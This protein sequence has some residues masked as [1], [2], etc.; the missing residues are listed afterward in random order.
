[1]IGKRFTT[2]FARYRTTGAVDAGGARTNAET[3]NLS[4]YCALLAIDSAKIIRNEKGDIVA[5]HEGYFNVI[6]IAVDDRIK[7]GTDYYLV[8]SLASYSTV[9]NKFMRAML[10]TSTPRTA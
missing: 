2:A 9:R 3:T 5:D 1:M 8:V 10:R 4:G 6:D 7:V